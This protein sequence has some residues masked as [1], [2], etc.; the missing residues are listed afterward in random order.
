MPSTNPTM[1]SKNNFPPLRLD[2]TRVLS[3]AGRHS[4]VIVWCRVNSIQ[5]IFQKCHSTVRC[6]SHRVSRS[7]ERESSRFLTLPQWLFDG[8]L[9]VSVTIS[10][11]SSYGFG[12]FEAFTP[13]PFTKLRFRPFKDLSCKNPPGQEVPVQPL[14]PMDCQKFC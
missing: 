13:L 14:E 6:D 7:R 4:L 12:L 2:L 1:F 8:I 10:Q 9:H 5:K 3:F 11:G